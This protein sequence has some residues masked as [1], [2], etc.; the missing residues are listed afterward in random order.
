M[1]LKKLGYTL[2]LTE[3]KRT[4]LSEI[5]YDVAKVSRKYDPVDDQMAT[6]LA[7]GEGMGDLSTGVALGSGMST[8]AHYN[9]KFTGEKVTL[10]LDNEEIFKRFASGDT[11]RLSYREILQVTSNYVPPDFSKKQALDSVLQGYRFVD[12]GKIDR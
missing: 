8:P 12:A 9:V 10:A 7:I 6:G 4:E 1:N 5:L 3:E 11:V 2:G